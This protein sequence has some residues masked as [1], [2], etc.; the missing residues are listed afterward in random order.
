[1]V[2][3]ES[4]LGPTT[5]VLPSS[6]GKNF[7]QLVIGG[8]GWVCSQLEKKKKTDK[9]VKCL[10]FFSEENKERD[11]DLLD[12]FG[13]QDFAEDVDPIGAQKVLD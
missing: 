1:L 12:R 8:V 5:I 10:D 13:L 9:T 11:T 3:R 4:V 2:V 6:I 7:K